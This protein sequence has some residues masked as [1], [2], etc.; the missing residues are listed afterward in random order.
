LFASALALA[1][2]IGYTNAGTVEF[3]VHGGEIALLEMHTRLQVEHS[4][5]E[6]ITGLD[7]VRLQI[8]VAS[9]QRLPFTQDE[10]AAHGSAIEARLYAEDPARDFLPSTGRLA[11]FSVDGARWDTGVESGSEI[12]PEFDGLLAKGVAHAATREEATARLAR[13]LRRAQVHGVASNRDALVAILESDAF[14]AADLSTDFLARQPELLQARAPDDVVRVH[15]LAAKLFARKGRQ[16]ARRVWRFVPP[17]WRNL[18]T[19]E[20]AAEPVSTIGAGWIDLEH[21]AVQARFVV[22]ELDTV[23]YVNGLGWQTRHAHTPRFASAEVSATARGTTAPLPGTVRA[24]LV[25]A[26]ERVSAGQ[27][28]VVLD[29]MKIEHHIAA[30]ADGEVV[31][32]RVQPG[33]RVDAH[34]VLVVLG[35]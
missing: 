25:S 32:V 8:E 30:E 35:P 9:G 34:Q 12:G 27:S 33:E 22:H 31:D 16:A 2:A 29:A 20:P 21:E 7:L 11:R 5:T 28:L 15:A 6:A 18:S 26:G 4:V 19:D 10:L 14:A 17:G 23:T 1:R 3:L 13:A 24:V